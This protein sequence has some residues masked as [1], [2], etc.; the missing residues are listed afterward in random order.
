MPGPRVFVSRLVKLPLREAEGDVIGRVADV[1]IAPPA[2]GGAPQLLGLV[3]NINRRNIFVA[4][5]RIATLDASGVALR[6]AALDLRPFQLRRSE[7]LARS[8]FDRRHEEFVVLDLG[9]APSA[10]RAAGWEVEVVALG[11][12]SALRRRKPT[13]TV[14]W[15]EIPGLFDAGAMASE[16]AAL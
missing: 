10:T 6:T 7:M 1:V 5:S 3:A 15:N 13:R 11:R 9:I 8:L 16:V 2:R 4:A 14:D 12:Q